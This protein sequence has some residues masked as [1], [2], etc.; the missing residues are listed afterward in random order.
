[1]PSFLILNQ[2]LVQLMKQPQTIALTAILAVTVGMIGINGALGDTFGFN[3]SPEIATND[4]QAYKG[5]IILKHFD[6]EGNL[7]GYQQT[8][9]LINFAGKNCA[10]FLTFG[11]AF[12]NCATGVAFDFI[13]L[14]TDTGVGFAEGDATLVGECSTCGAG[15]N[16]R[17]QGTVSANTAAVGTTDAIAQIQQSFT[18]T[19]AGLATIASAGLFNAV[20]GGEMFAE[21]GFASVGLNQNDSLLVTWLITVA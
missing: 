20:T 16:A 1:L 15:L 5:H 12:A 7:V 6:A 21:K 14:S 3:S 4:V 9:N 18:K 17:I 13:A 10:A 11:T 8:D 2:A 19:D